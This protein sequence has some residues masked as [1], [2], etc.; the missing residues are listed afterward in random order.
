MRKKTAAVSTVNTVSVAYFKADPALF[1]AQLES[2]C[3]LR[4]ITSQKTKFNL[5]VSKLPLEAVQVREIIISPPKDKPYY[6]LKEELVRRTSV[7]RQKK[8]S[9]LLHEEQLGDS[10]PSQFL[11]RLQ[12]LAGESN[13]DG[14]IRHIFLQRFPPVYHAVLA[15]V[16]E[17]APVEKLAEIADNVADLTSGC[18]AP[19]SAVQT[20]EPD[21]L[22][23][24]LEGQ[25]RL[26][27]RMEDLERRLQKVSIHRSQRKSLG[28]RPEATRCAGVGEVCRLIFVSDRITGIRFLVDSGA[29]ISLIP[30]TRADK[31]KGPHKLTLQAVNK[32]LIQTYGQRCLTLNLGLRRVFTHFFVLADVE[33]AILGEDFL[34]KFGLLIDV[35]RRCLTDPKPNTQS[36]GAIHNVIPLC[37]TVANTEDNLMFCELLQKFESITKPAF[38]KDSL[39]HNITHHISTS[40]P[41]HS[42]PRRLA[43]E[44]LSLA[45]AEFTQMMELGIIRPSK[46]NWA[47]PLHL[48]PKSGGTWRAC[49][50]YKALNSATKPDRYPIPHIHDVTAIIQDSTGR[51]RLFVSESMRKT[52]FSSMH[53]LS[54]PGANASIWLITDRFVWPR[55][56][57]D[58]RQWSKTC[59]PCQRA[60][61][62]R[63]T[64]SPP[65]SFPSPDERF[66]HVHVNITGPLPSCEGK[67][68]LLTCVDR[69]S[70]WCEALPMSD[71]TAHTTAKTF[72]SGWVSPPCCWFHLAK[73]DTKKKT[74]FFLLRCL[75]RKKRNSFSESERNQ[76]L[77]FILGRNFSKWHPV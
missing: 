56:K 69:L 55:M 46:S 68:Y 72:V 76:L 12:H 8:L 43:P 58:I 73:S 38:H 21:P 3:E 61:V 59:V 34:H 17:D 45:K 11:R 13:E 37:P 5:A 53:N 20:Q 26:E 62:R 75:L 63:H 66:A 77:I 25:R 23:R 18:T 54:H 42:R 33:K 24:L 40:G 64:R 32:S 48:V 30:A 52:L 47:S 29:Q 67:T 74:P 41:V 50:D 16:G 65:G 60:K 49:G 2:E 15:A 22:A 36:P 1:F 31:L 70:R 14:I 71:I 19:V 44:K 4:G 39:P 7:S 51:L 9:Q 57:T 27:A 28:W 6:K 35:H 10:K